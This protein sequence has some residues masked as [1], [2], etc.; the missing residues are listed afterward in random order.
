MHILTTDK[1]CKKEYGEKLYRLSFN[2]HMGCPNRGGPVLAGRLV[3][4]VVA[5]VVTDCTM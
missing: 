1:F 5:F 3:G 4:A 2:A